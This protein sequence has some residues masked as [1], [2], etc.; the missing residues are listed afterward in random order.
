MVVIGNFC[1][2]EIENCYVSIARNLL[3]AEIS[4]VILAVCGRQMVW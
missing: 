1:D 2:C 4:P 3:E